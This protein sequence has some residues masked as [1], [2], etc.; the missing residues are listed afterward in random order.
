MVGQQIPGV[1]VFNHQTGSSR[2]Y[3][4]PH[5]AQDPEGARPMGP[6]ASIP[7]PG[8]L[9]G[10]PQRNEMGQPTSSHILLH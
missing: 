7:G 2:V 10:N 6:L 9:P 3:V 5:Q 4:H 8:R 1:N